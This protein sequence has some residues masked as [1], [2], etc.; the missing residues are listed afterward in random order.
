MIKSY[1]FILIIEAVILLLFWFF[2]PYISFDENRSF[3]TFQIFVLAFLP[4]IVIGISIL[5]Q[6]VAISV[7]QSDSEKKSESFS[8][9][10]IWK[11][12]F[13]ANLLFVSFLGMFLCHL[14]RASL[15]LE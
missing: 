2:K 8:E 6:K 15:R 13:F 10:K 11:I 4:A 7:I 3:E 9:E 1:K 12:S 5:F 14:F